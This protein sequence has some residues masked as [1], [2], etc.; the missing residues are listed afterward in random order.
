MSNNE[1]GHGS[2]RSRA[3]D[4]AAKRAYY[5][6]VENGLWKNLKDADVVPDIENSINQLQELY[7][8]KY[9]DH[10]PEYEYSYDDFVNRWHVYCRT[11]EFS[12][13]GKAKSKVKAKKIA[14]YMVI[15]HLLRSAGIKND[16]WEKTIWQ[17]MEL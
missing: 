7:Q 6:I 8:K 11:E 15:V 13:W 9:L 2:T 17:N 1:V 10:A 5:V 12:G 4:D 14:A 3:R 16:D